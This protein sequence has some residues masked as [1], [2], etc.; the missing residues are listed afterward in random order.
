MPKKMLMLGASCF[1]K[2]A[3]EYAKSH[4]IITVAVDLRDEDS[5]ICKKIADISYTASTRDMDAL[6]AIA[7]KEQIDGIYAGASET[8]MPTA[9][10]L[11]HLLRIPFYCNTEQWKIGTN[12]RCFK[13]MCLRHGVPVTRF[14]QVNPDNYILAADNF[15]YPVVTKPVDN[16]GSTGITICDNR[17]E[18]LDG[19]R[20][21][22]QNSKSGDVL[23]EDYMPYDSV[24]IHYTM[25]NGKA[26]F[27]GM[28]DKQSSKINEE[29]A[30]VMA[31]QI[32]PSAHQ[33]SYCKELDLKVQSMYEQEGFKEGPI[34]IEAFRDGEKF[35][36][37]EMGYRFGG[38]MTYHPVKYFTGIDQIELMMN[39]TLGLA[40]TLDIKSFS[41]NK[42]GYYIVPIHISAGTIHRIEG[43]D[44][45]RA[46]KN[47]YAI[48]ECHVLGDKIISSGTVS[49][50]FCYLHIICEDANE[51]DGIIG[52]IMTMM[53]AEDRE[54]NNML[55]QIRGGIN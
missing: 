53:K 14:Y 50:V 42:G 33:D 39:Q 27:C 45:V 15:R 16:N 52:R 32:F 35:I 3:F 28:S 40:N 47:V 55:F 2:D 44:A 4:E 22:Q 12:K 17:A 10:Q 13:E 38:S 23:V 51:I 37:N 6:I 43:L 24:I 49:Q 19:Y 26:Y 48:S 5:A 46:D 29:G 1:F 34:W 20:K 7:Q 18:Y 41:H 9:I 36:F 11:A 54:G 25:I 8:N 31:M 21:A 30:P